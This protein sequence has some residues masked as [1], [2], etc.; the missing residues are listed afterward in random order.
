MGRLPPAEEVTGRHNK[1][2]LIDAD[3]EP[4]KFVENLT[5][6][7]AGAMSGRGNSRTM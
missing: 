3:E 1:R 4:K 6:V 2:I 5:K 7:G